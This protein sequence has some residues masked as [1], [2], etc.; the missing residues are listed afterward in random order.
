MLYNINNIPHG[1]RLCQVLKADKIRRKSNPV[2]L[3]NLDVV[4]EDIWKM[5]RACVKDGG[6]GLAAPQIGI[7][8]RMFV[9]EESP[10]LIRAYINPVFTAVK[11][12]TR[13]EDTEGCLSVPGKPV[14]VMRYDQIQVKWTEIN[15]DGSIQE[16]AGNRSGH[17]ARV[18][19]HEYDH[20]DSI[21]ILDR[22]TYQYGKKR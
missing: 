12:T 7:F 3:T 2:D 20:L 19:Q 15:Q 8:K 21:S 4:Q 1:I 22:H 13:I 5:I 17:Q 14:K 10:G 18:F 11:G 6:I 16:M 9:A